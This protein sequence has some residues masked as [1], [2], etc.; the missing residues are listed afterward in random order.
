M[1]SSFPSITAFLFFLEA[2]SA[3]CPKYTEFCPMDFPALSSDKYLRAAQEAEAERHSRKGKDRKKKKR[4]GKKGQESD[5]ENDMPV[6]H[7]VSSAFDA[8]EVSS[9]ITNMICKQTG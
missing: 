8:P 3:V 2:V 7:T 6:S 9:L 5:S 1:H 4:K